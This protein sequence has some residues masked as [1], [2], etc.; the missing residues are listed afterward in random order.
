MLPPTS[1]EDGISGVGLQMEDDESMEEG[2][3]I[4]VTECSLS[5]FFFYFAIYKFFLICL[6]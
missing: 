2:G 3:V 1:D 4:P 6:K 5:F